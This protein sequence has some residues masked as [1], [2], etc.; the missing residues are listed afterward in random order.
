MDLSAVILAGGQ[1]R[2]MGRDKALLELDGRSLL[3]HAVEKVRRLNVAELF[4]SGRSGVDYSQFGCPVL[5]DR[6]PGCGPLGG[7]E[8]ALCEC[9]SPL[10]LVLAVDL[11]R[12][13]P[14][15]LADL[16]THCTPC[17]PDALTRRLCAAPPTE[18]AAHHDPAT[19]V[20]PVLNGRL[21]PLA[22]IYPKVCSEIATQSLAASQFAAADFALACERA[23]HIHLFAVPPTVAAYFTN[24]NT[25]A[26]IAP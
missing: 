15:F 22:A 1:S 16:A 26:D 24:W 3:A 11:P 2:R 4:I 6:Q 17:R 8:R 9:S 5:D 18:P 10:L 23:G 21:E 13:T 14:E 12:M 20:V 7:I 25:P 19:G